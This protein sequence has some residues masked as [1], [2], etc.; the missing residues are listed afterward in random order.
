M[1]LRVSCN[2]DPLQ[3]SILSA[4]NTGS[5]EHNVSII[6]NEWSEVPLK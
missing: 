4:M 5:I 1:R 2:N 6:C 3:F